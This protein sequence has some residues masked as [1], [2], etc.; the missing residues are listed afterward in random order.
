MRLA[1]LFGLL[2]VFLAASVGAPRAASAQPVSTIVSA[3]VAAGVTPPV[4]V[5]LSPDDVVRSLLQRATGRVAEA[6]R[7]LSPSLAE[8]LESMLEQRR[9]PTDSV[10]QTAAA[11][12]GSAV[13]QVGSVALIGLVVSLIV[14]VTALGPLEGVIK[15]VEADVS[16]AFWRGLLAQTVTLPI[17]AAALLALALTVIGLLVVPVVAFLS[18]LAIAGVSTLGILAVAAVIGR[19]RANGDRAR[20]RSGL[21][22]A[23]LTGYGIIWAPWIAA[24][25]LVSVPVL[26][27]SV[28]I[29]ALA[30]T[31]VLA[32]V[33]IGA[34][35]RSRGGLRIPEPVPTR[36]ALA[37]RAPQPDWSTPTPVSGVVA[38]RRPTLPSTQHA[39][40]D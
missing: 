30:S 12:T 13:L 35:V 34:V 3:V 23:M 36:P 5:A 33:G 11:R 9:G 25:L 31:W 38:A 37:A 21:L 22:R 10:P 39:K 29:V 27:F 17:I 40:L 15:T 19:A 24:A 16:G 26:G 1:T 14:L 7:Q 8:R 32:T 2:A 20:S 18:V 6:A 28:R 4:S